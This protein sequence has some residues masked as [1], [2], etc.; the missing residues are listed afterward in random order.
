METSLENVCC[1]A[2]KIQQGTDELQTAL[3]ETGTKMLDQAREETDAY[4]KEK[5]YK[6]ILIAFGIG[7][8]T[9][10]CLLRR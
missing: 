5:P 4:I 7:A 10:L 1:A 6:A 9:T 2:Q 3:I 8:F